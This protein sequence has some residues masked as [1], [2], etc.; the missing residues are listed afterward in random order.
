MHGLPYR[1][2]HQVW[3]V[4]VDVLH[5]SAVKANYGAMQLV[6]RDIAGMVGARGCCGSL[7]G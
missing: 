2:Q 4:G 1:C 5:G 3:W 6:L 7:A